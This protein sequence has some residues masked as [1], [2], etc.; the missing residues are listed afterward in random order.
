M[1]IFTVSGYSLVGGGRET[2]SRMSGEYCSYSLSRF[3]TVMALV[4]MNALHVHIFCI[5]KF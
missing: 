1:R 2:E 4:K 3:V 5:G